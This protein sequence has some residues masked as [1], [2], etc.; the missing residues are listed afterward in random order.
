MQPDTAYTTSSGDASIAYQIVGNGPI[1]LVIA[2]GWIFHIELVWEDPSFERLMRKLGS[3]FRVIVFDKRGTGLSD[4][5][6]GVSTL[7]DR[8][9]DI[10][11]VM[12]AAGSE[13]AAVMGWSE[14]A[15][16]A[17]LFAATYPERTRALI[18]YAGGARFAWAPDYP[19]G[20]DA[21]FL[22]GARQ[23]LTSENWGKGLGAFIV[24][25][26]RASDEAFQKWFGRY[27]RFSISPKEGLEMMEI[28]MEIDLRNVLPLIS[29]PTLLL[30]QTG[31][32][33]IPVAMSQYM[34]ER[35]P[36]AKLVELPGEDHL[37]WFSNQDEVT[38]QL[39]EFV[40][41]SRPRVEPDRVLSTVLFTDIVGSTQRAAELGDARWRDLLED[42]HVLMRRLLAHHRGREVKTTGDGIL[43]TF[44]G[45]ARGARCAWQAARDVRRL[46]IEVRAGVHTG[47]CEVMGSD[48]GGLAVHIGDRILSLAAPGEVLASSTVKDLVAGSGIEFEDRG[49][50]QLKGV[51]GEWHLYA[52]TE[53]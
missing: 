36:G 48:V 51:P 20:Y 10:R 14:G 11:A 39:V 44:D 25:P 5:R 40:T 52:V 1:D 32:R 34:A 47:E 33:L 53:A 15:S 21:Q 45:P 6:V 28:N 27:E 18:M 50:H 12:D 3:T 16:I 26:T 19:M 49:L 41:G 43:A 22:D 29:V 9:D 31:D 46:G 17:M 8:M 2:P 13:R 24:T 37:W 42:H 38:D 35:I 23:L 4:R 30:H 7:E